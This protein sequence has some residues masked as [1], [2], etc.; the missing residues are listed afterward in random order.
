MKK[1]LALLALLLLFNMIGCINSISEYSDIH[2]DLSSKYVKYEIVNIHSRII[3]DP[4]YFN[5][6]IFEITKNK[7]LTPKLIKHI[8]EVYSDK[9]FVYHDLKDSIRND[10]ENTYNKLILKQDSIKYVWVDYIVIE[11]NN[12]V[13]KTSSYHSTH[14]GFRNVDGSYPLGTLYYKISNCLDSIIKL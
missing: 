10:I 1:L 9:Y 13:N 12:K 11:G 2:K 6:S 7:I 14:Y 3:S 8:K 4:D 5:D